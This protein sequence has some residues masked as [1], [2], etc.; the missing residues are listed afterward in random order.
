MRQGKNDA[1]LR[2]RTLNTFTS[3]SEKVE[4]LQEF[5]HGRELVGFYLARGRVKEAFKY[6]IG[7]G[8]FEEALEMIFD[9]AGTTNLSEIDEEFQLSDVFKYAQTKK[10]LSSI[11]KHPSSAVDINHEERFS[12]SSWSDPWASLASAANDYFKFGIKPAR[13]NI[14]EEWIREY[15]D[16]IVNSP[17]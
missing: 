1:H 9:R 8:E 12:G 10:L 6:S 13:D 3:D 15:L 2:E 7:A 16:T 5:K 11:S 4:F 17:P 14:R